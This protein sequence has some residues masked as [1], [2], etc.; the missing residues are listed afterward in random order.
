MRHDPLRLKSGRKIGRS[1]STHKRIFRRA[2]RTKNEKKKIGIEK[3]TFQYVALDSNEQ[4]VAK[5]PTLLN[6]RICA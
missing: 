1:G 4:R 6:L 5:L 2:K 3:I